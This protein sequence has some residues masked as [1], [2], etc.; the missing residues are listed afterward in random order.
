MQ[1]GTNIPVVG[2]L[3]DDDTQITDLSSYSIDALVVCPSNGERLFYSTRDTDKCGSITIA[4]GVFGFDIDPFHSALLIGNC[5]IELRLIEN[6][7]TMIGSSKTKK[8]YF[9]VE[10]N[11]IHKIC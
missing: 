4:Q 5:Y 9:N 3:Y 1:Q 2:K 10:S 11:E 6:G 7:S 8:L